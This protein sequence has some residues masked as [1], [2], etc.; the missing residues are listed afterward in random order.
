[1]RDQA[2]ALA[3]LLSPKLGGPSVFPPQPEGLWRAAFN[4][5][6]DYPTSVGDERYR[7]GLYVFLRRT[8]PNPTLSTFD[9][10][11]REACTFRRLPTNTPLQ[12]FVTLNDPVFVEAAQGLARRILRESGPDARERIRYALRL[13]LGR[14]PTGAQE[15]IVASHF[16]QELAHY[17]QNE[18]DARKLAAEP[19]ESAQTHHGVAEI[20]AWTSVANVLLNLDALL[21]RG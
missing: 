9:A 21:N 11:S 15:E 13:C 5:E 4:G 18:A 3:G 19:L 14:P 12:A 2:L 8:I 10:P 16:D 1:V 7:R 6:R 17:I 20:A